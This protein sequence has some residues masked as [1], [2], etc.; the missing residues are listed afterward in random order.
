MSRKAQGKT[1]KQRS[2]EAKTSAPDPIA[3]GTVE[4]ILLGIAIL[5][6]TLVA[7]WFK[8]DVNRVFDVPKALA[9]KVGGAGAFL[10]WL[11]YGLFGKGYR[12][13]SFKLFAGPVFAL[14]AAVIVS[15]L[16]SIDIPTSV[17]GVYER[18]FGL[19]GFLGCVGLFC[20]ASTCFRS[21]RGAIVGLAVLCILGGVIGIYAALQG[22]GVDPYGFFKKPHNKVYSTLGN[23][24]FAGNSLA[25]IAPI[26]TLL[27]LTAT[28][29][30]FGRRRSAGAPLGSGLALWGLGFALT[31]GIPLFLG[32]QAGSG[33]PR[34]PLLFK[35]GVVLAVGGLLA[36]GAVG[37]G[38]LEGFRLKDEKGRTAMDALGAGGLS[39]M[40]AGIF[41]GLI[42]TRTRGAWVG[43]GVAIFL[44]LILLPRLFNDAPKKKKA[45]QIGCYA[46]LALAL[47]GGTLFVTLSDHLY[48]RT[49]RSIPAA[50]DPERT[51]YGKGQG[52]RRFLWSESPRVLF[53]HGDTLER[54]YEDHDDYAKHVTP[55]LLGDVDGIEVKE[56]LT[57]SEKSFDRTWRK[58]A[59]WFFGIGVETY[60]YA[61]M[62]HKSKRL[63]ALDPMT[64]HDNPHNNYLYVL[65]SFG[66]VGLAAY[67]WLLWRLLSQAFRRF[68]AA[69]RPLL[70]RRAG[71]LSPGV[72][73]AW[74][75]SDEEDKPRLFLT[76][77]EPAAVARALS[78]AGGEMRTS[79]EAGR[80]V[81]TGFDPATVLERISSIQ[82]PVSDSRSERALAFGVVTSFFSYAV[83]SI[84]G[85]DSVACS[86]FFYFLLGTAAVFLRPPGDEPV[87]PL[88]V[89]LLRHIAELRKKDPASVP[90]RAPMGLSIILAIA[91]VLLLGN[92]ISGGL[93]VNSAE[94][95]FVGSRVR[96]RSARAQVER[97]IAN[98]K[99]AIRI[100]PY[101]SFYKQNLGNA[102]S[103]G[104]RVARAEAQQLMKQGHEQAARDRLARAEKYM[105]QAEVALYAALDHAWAPENIFISLFQVYYR[106]RDTKHAEAA[107]ERAL[108]HSPHLGAVRANLAILEL[109]REAW[110]EAIKDCEWV[111]EVDK[112]SA[113][114][115]R[116]CGRAY[117]MKGDLKKA[118]RYLKRA[119]AL[120]RKDPV[121]KKFLS[122]LRDRKRAATSTTG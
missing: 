117:T 23:A 110:D 54:M 28:T 53:N 101:E 21:R 80:V 98:I 30:A 43:T 9:L 75:L 58:V 31:L 34:E 102:Y 74:D 118:E 49:I 111:L 92:A 106:A 50:F 61:F 114:S 64:N 93:T 18:Q 96:A 13:S 1:D 121:V 29:T 66:L 122:D 77:E 105:E 19:Q 112:K 79:A 89:N 36:A 73:N 119:Q 40:A 94:Q 3:G 10:A 57:E 104:A 22:H 95:A 87:R 35:I 103:N 107:L 109:D 60:R 113:S 56:K 47:V 20:V 72:V 48:A 67:L 65:A 17:Y 115:W 15:T 100:N 78:E 83:Y 4:L 88:G 59:V 45:V 27:A 71:E 76:T 14:T 84:A 5:T 99:K 55:A 81:V 62:S 42:Y 120:N 70:K 68:I 90:A 86:V 7:L 39:A 25:L 2:A 11:L 26:S 6:V 51:D 85:F 16:L 37:T 33:S 52:T 12:Y 91:G 82:V 69:P 97:K 38:G 24:T 41:L 44:G 63:E 32:A 46:F 8:L 116:T 108:E